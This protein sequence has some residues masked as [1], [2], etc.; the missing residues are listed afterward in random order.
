MDKASPT[1]PHIPSPVF[2]HNL[3]GQPPATLKLHKTCLRFKVSNEEI[4]KN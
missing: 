1:N 3:T 4:A 2:P